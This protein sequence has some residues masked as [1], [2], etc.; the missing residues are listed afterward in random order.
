MN[1]CDKR[2]IRLDGLLTITAIGELRDKYL[3]ILRSGSSPK[4]FSELVKKL[5]AT[6]STQKTH[7]LEKL[8]KEWGAVCFLE[9]VFGALRNTD[10]REF[11][12]FVRQTSKEVRN[13]PEWKRHKI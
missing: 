5:E 2:D 9:N 1:K 7:E 4:E 3:E 12:E 13:W 6:E 11:W 10:R 8:I